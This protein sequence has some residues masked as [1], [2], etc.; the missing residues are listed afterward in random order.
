SQAC[1]MMIGPAPMIMMDEMSVLFGMMAAPRLCANC[2]RYND[3]AGGR[4][5]R[6]V[7]WWFLLRS[8]MPQ[9]SK[10][11]YLPFTSRSAGVA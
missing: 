5:G 3:R 6:M 4:K 11:G 1:P 7:V 8:S 2:R 9:W 10:H